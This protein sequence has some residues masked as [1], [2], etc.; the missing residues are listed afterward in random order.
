VG[1]SLRRVLGV[2]CYL[3]IYSFETGFLTEPK[4]PVSPRLIVRSL[5]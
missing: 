3:P 2:C 1:T 5:G 4:V